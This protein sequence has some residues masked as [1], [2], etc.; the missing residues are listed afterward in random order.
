[1]EAEIEVAKSWVVIYSLAHALA[2]A[3]YWNSLITCRWGTCKQYRRTQ[4]RRG[5]CHFSRG[6]EKKCRIQSALP[7]LIIFGCAAFLLPVNNAPL[8]LVVNFCSAEH[9]RRDLSAVYRTIDKC[10]SLLCEDKIY[11]CVC[12]ETPQPRQIRLYTKRSALGYTKHKTTHR[13]A[14]EGQSRSRA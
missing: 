9:L 5:D 7:T 4:S 12:V 3:S 13:R 11:M 8:P 2:V 6:R 1:V 10:C 14:S